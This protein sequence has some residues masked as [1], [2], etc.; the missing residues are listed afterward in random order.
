MRSEQTNSASDESTNDCA[1]FAWERS[2]NEALAK[3]KIISRAAAAIVSGLRLALLKPPAAEAASLGIKSIGI[4]WNI[5]C[6]V[7]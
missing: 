7:D 4:F 2:S 6:V 5:L 1:S 3:C